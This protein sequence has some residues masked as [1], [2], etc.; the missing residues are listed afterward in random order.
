[1]DSTS[2]YSIGIPELDEQHRQLFDCI[3]RLEF[4]ADEHQRGLAMYYAM[5]QLGGIWRQMC[6]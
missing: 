4:P 5:D 3:N 2:E 1:M 6:C